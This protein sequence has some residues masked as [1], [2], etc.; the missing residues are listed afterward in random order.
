MISSCSLEFKNSLKTNSEELT[1]E[2]LPARVYFL[3][4]LLQSQMY[5]QPDLL[6]CNTIADERPIC[7]NFVL[8]GLA[9]LDQWC[10]YF[11]RD[12]NLGRG[13]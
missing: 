7:V 1:L 11:C 10:I 8:G 12:K 13:G 4:A 3:K 6:V 9:N 5:Y 2:Q